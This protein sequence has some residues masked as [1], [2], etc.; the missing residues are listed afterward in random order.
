[1]LL[2]IPT[3]QEELRSL[4]LQTQCSLNLNDS[5]Y[6]GLCLTLLIFGTLI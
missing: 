3:I 5:M 1:M 2:K 4:S 6:K